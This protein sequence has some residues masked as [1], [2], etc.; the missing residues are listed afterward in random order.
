MTTVLNRKL[1]LASWM[2]FGSALTALAALGGLTGCEQDGHR[3]SMQMA[4]SRWSRARAAVMLQ[5]ADQQFKSG[6]PDK[7]LATIN[8]GARLDPN[9]AKLQTLRGQILAERGQ[10]QPAVLAFESAIALDAAAPEPHYGCAVQYERWGQFDKALEH[11]QSAHSLA[12][13]VAIYAIAQAET[14]G[15]LNRAAEA[16]TL[17]DEMLVKQPQSVALRVTAGKLCQAQSEHDRA[18]QYYRDAAR[19]ASDDLSIQRSLA[20][21][22]YRAGHY[23]E[24]RTCLM[25][26]LDQPRLAG[27]GE[28]SGVIKPPPP[29]VDPMAASVP[30]RSFTPASGLIASGSADP[31]ADSARADRVELLAA[32]GECCLCT[33][34][35]AEALRYFSE[36]TR[37]C[38][39][40]PDGW[41]GQARAAVSLRQWDDAI[42]AADKALALA[43]E[44]T[45]GCLVRGYAL[46]QSGRAA[47]AV[48]AFQQAH[49][50]A[51]RDVLV[52]CLLADS[53]SRAGN[54][55]SA[56]ETLIRA[57]Q[58]APDDPLA[59]R[60]TREL[61]S[62][63][64]GKKLPKPA[65]GE[66]DSVP[67]TV[68]AGVVVPE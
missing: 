15:H 1:L 22:L 48:S 62:R 4:E 14:L 40:Q 35:P 63:D 67:P 42:A 54:P 44:S 8:Q 61:A 53:F 19:L 59:Q 13:N 5:L 37:L 12:P 21:S 65:A 32:L 18:T 29:T 66:D 6:Q 31:S 10:G 36:L 16:L 47:Q 17:V 3:E 52:L 28:G 26:L 39:K 23:D 64:T 56:R 25:P 45:G 58:I 50:L 34:R 20:L 33:N 38:P 30:G 27:D 43:P 55:A 7:A 2:A 49:R 24:A 9:F 68:T 41:Q 11:Y 60:M 46:V 51:P 57:T